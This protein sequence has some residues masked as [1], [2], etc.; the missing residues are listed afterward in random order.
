MER[1]PDEIFPT[2]T[3][4]AVSL[5]LTLWSRCRSSVV[6]DAVGERPHAPEEIYNFRADRGAEAGASNTSRSWS[7]VSIP[8]KW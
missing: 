7:E 8:L 6:A 3:W 5:S 1:P 2:V 4:V